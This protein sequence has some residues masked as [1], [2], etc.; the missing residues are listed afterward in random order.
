MPL[1]KLKPE[2]PDVPQEQPKKPKREGG[3]KSQNSAAGRAGAGAADSADQPENGPLVS[4]KSVTK[5]MQAL[6]QALNAEK[7]VYGRS[8]DQFETQRDWPTVVRAAELI[9]AYGEGRP[10]ER[11]LEIRATSETFDAQK[12]RMLSS[13]EGIRFLLAAKAITE[14]EATEAF[15]RLRAENVEQ[16]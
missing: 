10:V 14:A 11:R 3:R 8:K 1:P 4:R 9:L 2:K 13:P 6:E 5:A 7:V 15:T 16:S 12:A